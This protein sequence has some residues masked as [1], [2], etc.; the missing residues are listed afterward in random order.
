MKWFKRKAGVE[1]RFTLQGKRL[2]AHVPAAAAAAFETMTADILALRLEKVQLQCEADEIAQATAAMREAHHREHERLQARITEE[3][4]ARRE[5]AE[6]LEQN[7]LND[8]VRG[9]NQALA[10]KQKELDK[11]LAECKR[12]HQLISKLDVDNLQLGAALETAREEIA[13]LKL[14]V[15]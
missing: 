11:A 1:I 3:R 9:L 8:I 6:A 2:A 12:L 5:T 13:G 15:A 7:G 4:A 14:A 10:L